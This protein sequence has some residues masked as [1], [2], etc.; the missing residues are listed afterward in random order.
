MFVSIVVVTPIVWWEGRVLCYFNLLQF[1]SYAGPIVFTI[2]N[3]AVHFNPTTGYTFAACIKWC[4]LCLP[5][6]LIYSRRYISFL[7]TDVAFNLCMNTGI[8]RYYSCLHTLPLW[9][10]TGC[11]YSRSLYPCGCSS[12]SLF[13]R[14]KLMHSTNCVSIILFFWEW[15]S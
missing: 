12:H 10:N 13:I 11:W 9:V 8:I 15:V 1:C 5:F 7:L 14:S 4:L 3:Y 6:C 2:H